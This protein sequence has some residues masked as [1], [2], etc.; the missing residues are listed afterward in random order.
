MSIKEAVVTAILNLIKIKSIWSIGAL[1]V[2]I[3]LTVTD[4]ITG[5]V[6]L[7]IVTSI[8]T[9]YFTK[10]DKKEPVPDAEFDPYPDAAQEELK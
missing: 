6:A 9:Y 5:E 3:F 10:Q 1:A 7:A 2:F 4:K 8:V